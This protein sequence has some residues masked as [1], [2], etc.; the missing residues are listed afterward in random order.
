MR[1]ILEQRDFPVEVVRLLR[2][3][4]HAE[5]GT[6]GILSDWRREASVTHQ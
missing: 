5:P 6:F 4:P 1:D 2:A 3:M